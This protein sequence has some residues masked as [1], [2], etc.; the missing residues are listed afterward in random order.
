M[1]RS[2]QEDEY[3]RDSDGRRYSRSDRKR[4]R[5]P[6]RHSRRARSRDDETDTDDERR[7]RRRDRSRSRR[8][9][10]KTSSNKVATRNQREFTTYSNVDNPFNDANLE[11]KFV[12]G[13]KLQQEAKRGIDA[14][15]QERRDR[16][17][18]EESRIELEKLRKK[19]EEREL[20]MKLREQEQL[21]MQRDADL[22]LLGDWEAKEEQFHLEQAKRRAGI[23]I[24]MG[25]AKPI[26]ILAI[27]VRLVDNSEADKTGDESAEE[28]D[29][30]E[31][32]G[33]EVNLEEPYRIFESLDVGEMTELHHDIKYYLSLEKSERNQQF[34]QAMLVV[35]E[36]ELARLKGVQGAAH[37][38]RAVGRTSVAS[39]VATDVQMLLEGK[40]GEQLEELQRQIQ[41]KLNSNEPMD[42]DYWERVLKALLVAKAKAKLDDIHQEMLSKRLEKLR[43]L[44]RRQAEKSRQEME[45]ALRRTARGAGD[46]P[47]EALT[48]A[49]ADAATEPTGPI[50]PYVRAM[51]PVPWSS[52]PRSDKLL[53][54]VDAVQD[55]ADLASQRVQVQQ[56]PFVP[57][58]AASSAQA[59]TLDPDDLAAEMF[60]MEMDRGLNDDE[61]IF[62]LEEQ[63]NRTTYQWQDKYRPRKPRYFNRVST[64]FEWNKYNQTHYDFDNPP[65][66][67]VQGYKFNVFYPDLIDKSKAPTYVVERESPHADT[68]VIRFKA[69]PPYEDIAFR[70]VNREWEYSHKKGFRSKFDRGVLQLHFHFKRHFYRR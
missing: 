59:P 13:K 34:W 8:R 50:E 29:E 49:M 14:R 9:S 12:W 11:Q 38:P 53:P 62:N 4:S 36:D 41:L 24:K 66:K 63:L 48:L 33:L 25:R 64:G 46:S 3:A 55:K 21:R 56:R 44:Q 58:A 17:R 6:S 40:T 42:V 1:P 43:A 70:I 10:R 35:C 52:I 23:R 18:R 7:A 16:E 15:E 37:D 27:N 69:G 67:V 60:R 31:A 32:A 22:A 39:V 20:E 5:S 54:V 19:R 65:P 51:S 30:D 45:Q 26:D 2:D 61:E 68:A 28:E 57:K 47:R